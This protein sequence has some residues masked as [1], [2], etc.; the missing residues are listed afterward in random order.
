MAGEQEQLSLTFE[1][2]KLQK[3]IVC[4]DNELCDMKDKADD[5]RAKLHKQTRM[6]EME[7]DE[8]R[9]Q[10][11]DTM[12]SSKR[13]E[14]S[15]QELQNDMEQGRTDLWAT[16]KSIEELRASIEMLKI[17]KD[18]A[19]RPA[20][21]TSCDTS[22]PL[23]EVVRGLQSALEAEANQRRHLS[24]LLDDIKQQINEQQEGKVN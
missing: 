23:W 9:A 7:C 20:F 10:L 1:K 17:N 18:T 6:L 11:E 24:T 5:T 2:A 8:L 21:T 12:S 19:I 15:L 13:V 22:S 4:L 14:K 3:E 16:T